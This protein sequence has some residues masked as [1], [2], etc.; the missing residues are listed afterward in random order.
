MTHS[1]CPPVLA[2]EPQPQRHVELQDVRVPKRKTRLNVFP[3]ELK[4]VG[5]RLQSESPRRGWR[6]GPCERLDDFEVLRGVPLDEVEQAAQLVKRRGF[7]HDYA[8]RLSAQSR[9]SMR[10]LFAGV[11]DC[12]LSIRCQLQREF[13]KA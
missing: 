4:R 3:V 5:R 11:P 8:A 1:T 9:C 10:L 7:R 6:E 12:G 2:R 13:L